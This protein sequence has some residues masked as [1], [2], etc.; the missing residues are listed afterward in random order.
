MKTIVPYVTAMLLFLSASCSKTFEDREKCPCVLTLDC[1]GLPSS[2]R[3]LDVWIID[4][5]GSSSY[6]KKAYISDFSSPVTIEINRLQ[7]TDICVWGN[8]K[9]T[10]FH[11][12]GIDTYFI[13]KK[14]VDADSLY[15]E[16]EHADS[17]CDELYHKLSL[18]K[19]FARVT[20]LFSPSMS[21]DTEM[22]LIYHQPVSGYYIEGGSVEGDAS[23]SLLLRQLPDGQHTA[24][25]NMLR[26]DLKNTSELELIVPVEK[27]GRV[28][29]LIP[30]WKHLQNAGF[31]MEKRNLD[32]ITFSLDYAFNITGVAIT[33]WTDCPPYRI[34]F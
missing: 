13:K 17:R 32:D 12:S 15:R 6:M 2:V 21:F 11:G 31:D 34:E 33:D 30:I 5:S 22:E 27:Q 26:N 4:G 8:M 23:T 1:S 10:E 25:F 14:R 24:S 19:E 16:I 18:T 7:I 20:L 28:R 9:N 29:F 3:T